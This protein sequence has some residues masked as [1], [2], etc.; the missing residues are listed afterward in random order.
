MTGASS[1]RGA[2][3]ALLLL[4]GAPGE[5]AGQT[6]P[7]PDIRPGRAR[8]GD[9]AR[10]WTAKAALSYVATGGNAE[11]STLGFKFSAS[12][13]WTR[14]YFS[15][16]GGGLRSD[17]TTRRRFAVGPSDAEFSVFESETTATTAENYFL[18]AAFDRNVNG[19]FFW[20]AGA[21]WLRNPFSGISSRESVRAGMG[22][23]WTDPESKA[24]Q[25]KTAALATVTRQD[26][27]NPDPETGDTFAGARLLLDLAAPFG[28]KN[29]FNSRVNLD[30]NLQNGRDFRMVWWNSL[31]V[32][33]TDRLG[34]Q[35]SLL[36]TYDNR[37]ALRL[38]SRYE[39]TSEGA[40][41]G[42]PLGS[43]SVPLEKWDRE[44]AVSFVLNLVPRKPAPPPA[45]V[46]VR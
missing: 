33:M 14:T 10:G 9:N 5:A 20:Q 21:G 18:E 6:P 1:F 7:P 29:S 31:G 36:L 3:L 37:P 26:E 28:G 45:P 43:V 19:R 22:L 46:G 24:A 25:L 38:I 44:L 15:L 11:A 30:E 16:H 39:E 40:P 35:V 27:R 23:I 34:L 41:V 13:N 8:A 42:P 2:G 17:T 12:H 4:A 32:S